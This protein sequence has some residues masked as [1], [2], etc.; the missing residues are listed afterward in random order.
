M[1]SKYQTYLKNILTITSFLDLICYRG[2]IIL[3]AQS[4]LS[5]AFASTYCIHIL[6]F[7]SVLKL[8]TSLS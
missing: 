8:I 4:E 6:V 3:R 2:V 7:T 5:S 1:K